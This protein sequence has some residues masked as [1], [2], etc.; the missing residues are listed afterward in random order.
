MDEATLQK[1]SLETGGKYYRATPS[2][3]ELDKIYEDISRMEKKELEG[4]LLLHYDDRFQ[5]PLALAML[6]ILWEVFI[7]ER[8]R[9]KKRS[10]EV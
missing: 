3:L 10:V 9:T 5:W 1:I 6:F 8:V 7:P 4:K 2:E